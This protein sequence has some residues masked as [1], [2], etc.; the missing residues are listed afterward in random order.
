MQLRTE[1]APL[2]VSRPPIINLQRLHEAHES[3][4]GPGSPALSTG[5]P[6][7]A[8]QIAAIVC[9]GHVRD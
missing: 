9:R 2:E 4:R 1:H 8:A 6:T 7:T 3:T 5:T